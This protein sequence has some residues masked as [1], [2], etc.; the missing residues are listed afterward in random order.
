MGLYAA[1]FVAF[2][3]SVAVDAF[4]LVAPSDSW[5]ELLDL[6]LGQT[7]EFGDAHADI[8]SVQVIRGYTTGGS[9]GSAATPA[10]LMSGGKAAGSTVK[11]NNTT[12]ATAGTPLILLADAINIMAGYWYYPPIPAYPNQLPSSNERIKIAPSERV[13]VRLSAPS[14]AQNLNGTLIFGEI[15]NV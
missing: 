15:G 1:T 10:P 8:I 3:Q 7:S 6:R 2:S 11:T 4:E 12:L 5:V 9:G 13:V 14:A